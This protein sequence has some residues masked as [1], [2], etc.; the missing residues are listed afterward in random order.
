MLSFAATSCHAEISDAYT[1]MTL[2]RFGLKH[3]EMQVPDERSELQPTRAPGSE[4]DSYQRLQQ[5]GF[6]SNPKSTPAK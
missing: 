6:K 5:K 4:V 1:L 3:L 2:A